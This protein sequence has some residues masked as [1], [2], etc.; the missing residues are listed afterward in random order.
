MESGIDDEKEKERKKKVEMNFN[1]QT[2]R[3]CVRRPF[4]C[5]MSPFDPEAV[6]IHAVAALLYSG[7][8]KWA[9]VVVSREG[10]TLRTEQR[11]QWRWQSGGQ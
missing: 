1:L 7:F 6:D 5:A 11:W 10:S 2:S 8:H 4:G 9:S 3:K